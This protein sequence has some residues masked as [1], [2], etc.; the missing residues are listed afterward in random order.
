ML[1]V[2]FVNHSS[3]PGARRPSAV[4]EGV[5]QLSVSPL[6]K[7]EDGDVAF[8]MAPGTILNKTQELFENTLAESLQRH[9]ANL[10]KHLPV[11]FRH[12]ARHE[13]LVA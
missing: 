7:A 10:A 6:N 3:S 8:M 9:L 11:R 12:I 2:C 1:R 13:F 4:V 5:C